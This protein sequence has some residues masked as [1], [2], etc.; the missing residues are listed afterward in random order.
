MQPHIASIISLRTGSPSNQVRI[1]LTDEESDQFAGLLARSRREHAQWILSEHN[2]VSAHASWLRAQHGLNVVAEHV[3]ERVMGL[4]MPSRLRVFRNGHL[5]RLHAVEAQ[6]E[7]LSFGDDA[8]ALAWYLAGRELDEYGMP[9]GEICRVRIDGGQ[10]WA[11]E[12]P[13][14]LQSAVRVARMPRPAQPATVYAPPPLPV[15]A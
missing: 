5:T 3:L 7:S 15:A 11:D 8:L 13:P 6:V 4:K 9:T 10:L 14:A 2:D 1:P 12:P